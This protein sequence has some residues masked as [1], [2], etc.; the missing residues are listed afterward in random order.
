MEFYTRY[1]REST[2]RKVLR[3]AGKII[4]GAVVAY[5]ALFMFWILLVMACL[6]DHSNAESRDNT[7]SRVMLPTVWKVGEIIKATGLYETK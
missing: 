5:I 3:I 1:R 6:Q 4:G 2:T 7:L